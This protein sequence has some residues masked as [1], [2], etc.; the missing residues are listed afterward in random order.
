MKDP[1]IIVISGGFYYFGDLVE[2]PQEGYIALK[3]ASMFGGFSGGKGL[4]G[5]SRGDKEAQ[6]TLDRFEADEVQLFPESACYGIL[7]SVNLYD[8]K[9]TTVR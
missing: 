6:V 1:K 7:S 8:F 4:P 2:S 3:E 9:G 5:V